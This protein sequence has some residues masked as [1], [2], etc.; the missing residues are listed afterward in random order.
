M[1]HEFESG[2]VAGQA[3]WHGLAKVLTPEQARVVTEEDVD[4]L[5]SEAGVGWSVE[6][7]KAAALVPAT[8]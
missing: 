6:L 4:R 2:I 5:C 3:A 1:A 7:E 8:N